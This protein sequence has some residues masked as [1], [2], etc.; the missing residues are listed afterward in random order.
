[1]IVFL[2]GKVENTSRIQN[3]NRNTKV[4]TRQGEVVNE[5]ISAGS[6]RI[7]LIVFLFLF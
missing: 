4:P 7:I 6:T 3:I 2:R 1:M 5:K